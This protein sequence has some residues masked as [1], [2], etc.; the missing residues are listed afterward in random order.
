MKQT[1]EERKECQRR[2]RIKNK[3]RL[4]EKGREYYLANKDTLSAKQKVYHEANRKDR[5][6][7]QKI[8]REANKET[9]NL[10]IKRW[11]EANSEWVSERKKKWYEDTYKETQKEKDDARHR[12]LRDEY[13]SIVNPLKS[14]PCADCRR[15]YPPY[16]MDFDHIPGLGEKK[17]D[18]SRAQWGRYYLDHIQEEIAKCEVVCV[19]C[20]RVRTVNRVPPLKPQRA[21]IARNRQLVLECRSQPCMSCGETYNPWAMEFDHVRGKKEFTIS[22]GINKSMEALKREIEKCDILCSV[23]HRIKTWADH[24]WS[25]TREEVFP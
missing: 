18:I 16:L 6:A 4:K 22:S 5:L 20:H 15:T 11:N 9:V 23:C 21:Y 2:W 1:H 3:A 7:K 8:Y 25:S 19:N 10:G 14:V 17:F 13:F 24:G 12:R